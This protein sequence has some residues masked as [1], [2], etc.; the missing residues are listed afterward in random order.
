MTTHILWGGMPH[1]KR[2]MSNGRATKRLLDLAVCLALLPFV[3]PVCLVA[4]IAVRIETRGAPL[5]VQWRVGRHRRPFR[6][7]KLRTM[8]AR[9][10]D[11]PSHE[12]DPMCITRVGRFLRRT[13]L[14]ELP[15]LL[16]VVVGSMSLV[17]PRPCLPTQ[18]TLIAERERYGLYEF[19]PGVTGPAQLVGV[20]MSDPV[21]LARIEAEYFH[22]ATPRRDL[23]LI[24]RTALGG[25]RGD[26]ATRKG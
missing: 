10:G 17:G 9:S 23:S 6:L 13:K 11:L 5:F 25:G 21:L 7:L 3:L 2:S 15:Q 24:L 19:V 26:A 20:D 8:A 12:I 18:E 14:D 4:L 16:N 1:N 22:V